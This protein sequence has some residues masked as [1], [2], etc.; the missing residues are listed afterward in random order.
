M[1]HLG[2]AL[3]SVALAATFACTRDVVEAR[4]DAGDAAACSA[5]ADD[6]EAPKPTTP[7]DAQKAI[8][9]AFDSYKI[10][11]GMNA[12]HGNK[13]VDDFILSLIRNPNFPDK[14]NDIAVECGNAL[15]QD[16]LDRY[17]AGEDVP[18]SEVRK[19]WR[20]STQPECGFSTFQEQLFPLVR[21]INQK[22][23]PLKQLRILACDPP[24]DWS[25]VDSPDD[26]EV[27]RAETAA[28][29][30]T[31]E[32]LEKDR[33]A[34]MLYGIHHMMHGRGVVGRYEQDG[35][36]NVTFV[37][38]DH[39]GFGNDT[40]LAPHNDELEAQMTL[41]PIPSIVTIKDTW[42]AKLDSSYFDQGSF[43]GRLGY[44]GVDGYLYV[45]PR[46]YLL[47]EPRSAQAVLDQEYIA[48]LKQRA[49]NMGSPP[50]APLRPEAIFQ[51][52][53]Q[54]SAFN[55]DPK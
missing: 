10:V 31:K 5:G 7:E 20:N 40:P 37:I 46:G 29:V 36:T 53:S 8:M 35:Y 34:L 24:V 30:I 45:G 13:D 14:V 49:D 16:I 50:D 19:V 51:H 18:L 2:L 4:P 48:E 22:L 32:V 55:Y 6:A 17:I 11:G 52:E 38:A 3:T 39:V 12:S 42:L 21:R 25:K 26:L 27:D 43:P 54:S 47:R 44:P 33:K 9:A 23:P 28:A 41:W 1:K 15:Y